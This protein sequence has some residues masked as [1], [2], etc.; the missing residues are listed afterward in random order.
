MLNEIFHH[1]GHISMLPR[2]SQ[3]HGHTLGVLG[4]L[5]GGPHLL[6][7]LHL[8]LGLPFSA[9][10][11]GLSRRSAP[12][13]KLQKKFITIRKFCSSMMLVGAGWSMLVWTHP[14][15]GLWPCSPAG[16]P[17]RCGPP[18]PVG[19][20]QGTL[21]QNQAEAGVGHVPSPH[22]PICLLVPKEQPVLPV[23]WELDG[24]Q[25]HMECSSSLVVTAATTILRECLSGMLKS[26]LLPVHS[27]RGHHWGGTGIHTIVHVLTNTEHALI[28]TGTMV[29]RGSVK[30]GIYLSIGRLYM[31][32]HCRL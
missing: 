7:Q 29:D 27:I 21:D 1:E 6:D 20:G 32:R 2:E 30:T 12:G 31:N 4:H 19:T 9:S 5:E 15:S 3:V 23:R 13:T 24:P 10:M 28:T 26:M 16:C 25:A 17:P 11:S 8:R 14:G 18:P 22:Q